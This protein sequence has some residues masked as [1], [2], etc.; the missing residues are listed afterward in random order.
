M[1]NQ[2]NRDQFSSIRSARTS[3][4]QPNKTCELPT[5]SVWKA[6]LP[7]PIRE[8]APN[9]SGP[10]HEK[11]LTLGLSVH[12]QMPSAWK[13]THLCPLCLLALT[14][15]DY[16]WQG[17]EVTCQMRYLHPDTLSQVLHTLPGCPVLR[18]LHFN[19]FCTVYTNTTHQN[20]LPEPDEKFTLWQINT[21]L[22]GYSVRLV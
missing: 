14:T 19:M 18:G 20:D 6:T 12:M 5:I 13:H 4:V 11:T 17:N 8:S 15:I 16:Y 9:C 10:R 2:S 7:R 1:Y 22:S 3:S 21:S